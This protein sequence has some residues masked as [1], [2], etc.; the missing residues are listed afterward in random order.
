G[1]LCD[2]AIR[3][4]KLLAV[5]MPDEPEALGLLALMLLQD[6]RRFARVGPDGELVLLEDQDRSLWNAERIAEGRRVLER[7]VALRRAGPYQLQA[8]IAAA[9]AEDRSWSEIAALYDRLVVFDP[10]PVVALNRAVAVAL[11]GRIEDGLALVDR[12]D[13]LDGYH[14]LHAARADLLRRLDRRDEAAAAYRRA[15]ELAANEAE[16]RYLERRLLEVS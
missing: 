7:A 10:S 4:G 15:L 12:L 2:E 14:L 11:S 13:E 9:H 6:S 5:L 16:S 8:A 3:L 1:D